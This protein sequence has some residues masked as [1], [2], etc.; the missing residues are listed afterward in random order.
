MIQ[1]I[2]KYRTELMGIAIIGVILFHSNIKLGSVNP[3]YTGYGGVDIFL[4]LSGY[5]LYFAYSKGKEFFPFYRKRFMRVFPTYAVIVL[6]SMLCFGKFSFAKYLLNLSTIGFWI[7]KNYF[8]WYVPSLFIFYL[9]FPFL[10]RLLNKSIALYGVVLLS[11]TC[12]LATIRIALNLDEMLMLFIIRIPVFSLG[13]IWGKW[14]YEKKELNSK[15][16]SL[17]YISFIIGLILLFLSIHYFSEAD[18]WKYGYYWYP[19]ILITPGLCVLISNILEKT[20]TKI[21]NGT[22]YFLGT[23]S[24]EL[25][26]FHIKVFE[27]ASSIASYFHI[28]RIYI[29]GLALV[30][31]IPLSLAVSK[32]AKFF[33]QR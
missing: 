4:F 25:Y 5:G 19:F 6:I 2:S 7:H 17:V 30:I 9:L 33:F 32:M 1:N 18:S 12:L 16:K 24:L 23:L 20:N 28:S 8:E 3:F 10:Y 22:L 29:L 26:L 21:V 11:A 27:H 14:A 13:V 15:A 31:I